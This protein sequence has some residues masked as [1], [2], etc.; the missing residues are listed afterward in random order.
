VNGVA[1]TIKA[2][3]RCRRCRGHDL[4]VVTSRSEITITAS[5]SRISR[6]SASSNCPSTNCKNSASR[7][8]QIID[9]IQR[10]G[11]TELIISTPGPIGI[12]ALLAPRCSVCAQRIYHTDFPQYVRIL[13]DDNFLET[14]TWNYMKWFYGSSISYVNSEGYRRAWTDRG[15]S[16]DKIRILPR[17]LDTTLFTPTRREPAFWDK[18][19]VARGATVLL[20]VGRVSKEKDLDVI[21]SAW[22]RLRNGLRPRVGPTRL[23][24]AFVGDGP[25][26]KEL[27]T[28]LPDAG[29]HRLPRGSGPR[30]AFASSDVLSSRAPRTPTA[31]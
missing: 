29:L 27:R 7:P 8:S 13:T 2:P 1:T 3:H 22:A 28:L 11:F 6:P 4:V 20:Y 14:L 25:Y 19:G 31:T 9:Y 30:R 12:T 23:H 26:L 16:G 21:V 5:R 17:G 24:L 18:Y 15:I 10:E